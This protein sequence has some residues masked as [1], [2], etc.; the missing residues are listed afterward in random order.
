MFC[1]KCGTK[2]PDNTKY[3]S[4][5]G[6]EVNESGVT[7]TEAVTFQYYGKNWKGAQYLPLGLWRSSAY[8]DVAVDNNY[9]Y[10]I[11]FPPY[12][13]A[14]WY[15]FIGL[16]LLNIIGVLIGAAIG[17]NVDSNKRASFRSAWIDEKDRIISRLYEGRVFRKIPIDQL[18]NNS[19]FKKAA[20]KFAIND[21]NY[22]YKTGPN[23]MTKFVSALGK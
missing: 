22:I 13:S 17:G 23:Q 10:L 3:C 7:S 9:V 1:S 4:G 5:C 8:Y 14:F 20:I 16:F 11:K 18:K 6:L 12:S 15:G 2:N 21:K 19:T